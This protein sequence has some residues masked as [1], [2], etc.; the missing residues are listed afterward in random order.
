MKKR[1]KDLFFT[2]IERL[3][4]QERT[5]FYDWKD[6]DDYLFSILDFTKEELCEIYKDRDVI[7]YIS[8]AK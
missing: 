8:S 6:A 1:N 5:N 2:L 4:A 3:R 7:I